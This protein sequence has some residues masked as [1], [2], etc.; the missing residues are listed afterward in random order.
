MFPNVTEKGIRVLLLHRF[1]YK[2]K[3]FC[4]H[5]SRRLLASKNNA[6]K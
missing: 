1:L 3:C 4:N 2:L 5:M 6:M